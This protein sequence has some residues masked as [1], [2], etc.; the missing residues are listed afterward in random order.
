MVHVHYSAL[1]FR[2]IM[3]ATGKIHHKDVVKS[4]LDEVIGHL[5]PSNHHI[6]IKI[7]I[8]KFFPQEFVQGM[9]YSGKTADGQRV[10]GIVPAKAMATL[11]EADVNFMLPVPDNWT[12]EEAATVPVVYATV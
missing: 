4:R 6:G 12:L 9:E 2:D 1:N 5:L 3:L 7:K 11:V 8:Y 10:M